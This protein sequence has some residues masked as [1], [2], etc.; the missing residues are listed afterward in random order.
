MHAVG[1]MMCFAIKRVA[2]DGLSFSKVVEIGDSAI[3]P[4]QLNRF[5]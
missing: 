4:F 1:Q 2:Y 3:S 5:V